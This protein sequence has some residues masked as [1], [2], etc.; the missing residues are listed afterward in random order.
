MYFKCFIWLVLTCLWRVSSFQ[1]IPNFILFLT[2]DQDIVLNSMYGDVDAGGLKH[3]PEGYDWWLGLKGNSRYYNYTLSVNGTA[4]FYDKEYLTDVI[5]TSALDFIR[6]NHEKPFFMTLATP[7]CHAPFTAAKRHLHEFP[8]EKVVKNPSFNFSSDEKHWIVKMPP[9]SLPTNIS[10]LDVIQRKRLQTLLAVD[11]MVKDIVD[12]LKNLNVY[13]NTYLIFT[14]D[15]GFHIGQFGQPWDKRQPYESDIKVPFFISGPDVPKNRVLTNVITAIDIAPTILDLADITV[16]KDM[17]GVSLKKMLKQ[18]DNS[19]RYILIEYWG[20]GNIERID[21]N[22][23]WKDGNL[24]ECS[25]NSWCKCQ[26]SRNNTYT[27]VLH[28]SESTHFKMCIFSDDLGFVEAYD[29]RSDPFE[30]RNIAG[31]IDFEKR[32]FYRNILHKLTSC[33]GK[34]CRF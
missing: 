11:E 30:L 19:Q 5:T 8:N 12:E 24:T 2:D 6:L 3:V 21:R 7:A 16:P 4:K 1:S 28:L 9:K 14:S 27:C 10:R 26:D 17:D 31:D 22:C 29:L 15:N 18:Y 33:E 34:S 20:E 13:S 32:V 25:Q 23:P